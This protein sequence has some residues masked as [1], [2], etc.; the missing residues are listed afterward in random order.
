MGAGDAGVGDVGWGD[1][2]AV[3]QAVGFGTSFF[4]TEKMMAKD[5]SQALPIT[6]AQCAVVAAITACWAAVDG[7]ALDGWML[8]EGRRA[9]STLPGLLLGPSMRTVAAAALWTGLV[10]TAANRFARA[11]PMQFLVSS[12]HVVRADP[13]HPILTR[14]R[15]SEGWARRPP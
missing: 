4:I 8:D 6:A 7:L 12:R 9:V 3:L 2:W 14:T 5:P 13:T 15:V 10:T 11:L 1:A